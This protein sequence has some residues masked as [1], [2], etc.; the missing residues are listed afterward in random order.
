[1][2]QEKMYHMN[3]YRYKAPRNPVIVQQGHWSLSSGGVGWWGSFSNNLQA[4]GNKQSHLGTKEMRWKD[5]SPLFWL[6][7]MLLQKK[8]KTY[9][10]L[11]TK[12]NICIVKCFCSF[13]FQKANN[14]NLTPTTEDDPWW[15]AFSTTCKKMSVF[16]HAL[17]CFV[18]GLNQ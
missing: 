16:N 7:P 8:H 18:K 3:F 5:P 2:K 11:F 14:Y 4:F 9:V 10:I 6:C 17:C 12:S 1:M 13:F 15:K